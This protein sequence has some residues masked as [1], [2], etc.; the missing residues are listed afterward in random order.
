MDIEECSFNKNDYLILEILIGN[1]CFSSFK[2]LTTKYLIDES[3][4]SHVKVRQTIKMFQMYNLVKDGAKD[5]NNRTYYV[6]EK[7]VEFFMKVMDCDTEDIERMK[8]RYLGKE[9]EF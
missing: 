7:G 4:F 3:K 5:G 2:S 9:G 1:E 6:T 8:D